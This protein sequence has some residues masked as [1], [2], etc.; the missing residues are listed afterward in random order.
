MKPFTITDWC[1]AHDPDPELV[2][3]DSP[4]YTTT[5]WGA[6]QLFAHRVRVL[7]C[8]TRHEVFFVRWLAKALDRNHV[9]LWRDHD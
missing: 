3:W 8:V 2:G 7:G 6:C 1:E 9:L 4:I 5:Y